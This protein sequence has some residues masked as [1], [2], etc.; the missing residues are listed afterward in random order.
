MPTMPAGGVPSAVVRT[1]TDGQP[2]CT[3]GW[4]SALLGGG[5][6]LPSRLKHSP[7]R[8]IIH[9]RQH[10]ILLGL[11]AQ[12]KRGHDLAGGLGPWRGAGWTTAAMVVR[13]KTNGRARA[14]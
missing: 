6:E 5:E 10:L 11:Y 13:E 1:T 8:S 7:F 2:G 12:L 14:Q 9:G 3:S 4:P